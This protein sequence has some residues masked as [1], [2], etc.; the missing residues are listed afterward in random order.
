MG[1]VEDLPYFSLRNI[2]SYRAG[3]A[4]SPSSELGNEGN[5]TEIP[6][7]ASM[8]CIVCSAANCSHLWH[9]VREYQIY[10]NEHVSS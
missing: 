10:L 1:L 6:C 9:I 2:L 5:M 8:S 4:P 7:D 3:S